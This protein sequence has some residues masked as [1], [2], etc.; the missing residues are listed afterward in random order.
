MVHDFRPVET[1]VELPPKHDMFLCQFALRLLLLV[2][3]NLRRAT[4]KRLTHLQL[5]AEIMLG[6]ILMLF[7]ILIL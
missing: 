6:E 2:C 1:N 7:Q 4:S 5:V 3:G